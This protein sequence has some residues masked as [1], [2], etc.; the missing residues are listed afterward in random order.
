[1]ETIEAFNQ[2]FFLMI[3]GTPATS[4]WLVGTALFAANYLIWLVPFVLVGMWLT[5][6]ARQRE[7]ALRA[8]RVAMLALGANQ[9]IGLVWQHPRPFTLG[10]GH[11]FL[12]HAP[13]SSFPSDHATV[14]AG[15]ALTLLA[16]GRRW[17]G[18][19]TLLAG[20][21]SHGPG[22]FSVYISR[23]TCSGQL[24]SHAW[25]MGRSLRSGI[26]VEMR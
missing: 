3:N 18:G 6:K 8:C 11:T 22:F 5:G 16:G 25:P 23:S 26:G 14:F 19:C 24:R 21:P 15:V 9:L 17:L 20:L 10:L 13:D 1:M 4:A 2:A 12:V 7:L